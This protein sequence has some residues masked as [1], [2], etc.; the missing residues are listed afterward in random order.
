MQTLRQGNGLSGFTKRS[1]SKYDPF[2]A[3]SRSTSISAGLGMLV[4]PRLKRK[5]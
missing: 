1:G 5:K 3:V 4:S 2:G